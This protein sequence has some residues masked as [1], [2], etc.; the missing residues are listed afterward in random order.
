[1]QLNFLSVNFMERC[2]PRSF[3]RQQSVASVRRYEGGYANKPRL[4]EQRGHF[5]N[6]ANIFGPVFRRK[7]EV[8][9][10]AVANV[11]A[12]ERVAGI[13]HGQQALL[14]PH[15]QRR[16][17]RSRKTSKPDHSAV[18]TETLP[19][20]IRSDAVRNHHEVFALADARIILQC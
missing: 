1:M 2:V 10:Q 11:V 8:G 18:V 7:A 14:Q 16:L 15:R 12:I 19:A 3:S 13:A 5:T 6:A 20:R 4:S 9:I 17:A